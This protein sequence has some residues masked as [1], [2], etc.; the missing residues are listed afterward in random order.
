VRS[1]LPSA[2]EL[3]EWARRWFSTQP[4]F[5]HIDHGSSAAALE[6]LMAYAETF[7]ELTRLSSPAPERAGEVERWQH[8]YCAA[9]REEDRGLM[10]L[11]K[12]FERERALRFLREVLFPERGL[13]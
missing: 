9:H 10:L 8:A 2:G 6:A 12:L 5:T 3:P 13:A 7:V 4:L 11:C 1:G